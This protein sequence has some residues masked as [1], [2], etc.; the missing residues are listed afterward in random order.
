MQIHNL[1]R[2]HANTK[3]KRV[4]R[5]GKRGKT[6]GRGT[7]GQKARAGRKMRP[8]M[9]DNIKK[10]P[11][12]RGYRFQSINEKPTIVTT[13]ALGNALQ[14]GEKVTPAV[15]SAHG[16]IASRKGIIPSV[17]ILLRGDVGKSLRIEGCAISKGA[18]EHIEKAGG[19]VMPIQH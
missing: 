19:S 8:E 4:G 12:L 2:A 9:R 6:S 10:L 14:S 17:K 5:G 16:L 1:K 3:K 15:L 18:R 11:K 13:G 7:K